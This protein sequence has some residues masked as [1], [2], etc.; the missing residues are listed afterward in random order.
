MG[1]LVIGMGR[2][3]AGPIFSAVGGMDSDKVAVPNM[4]LWVPYW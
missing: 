3:V 2:D 1:G 4:Y